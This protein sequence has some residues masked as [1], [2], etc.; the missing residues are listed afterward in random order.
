M[1]H[2]INAKFIKCCALCKYWDD[3]ARTA[4]KPTYAKNIWD[5]DISQNR[6]CMKKRMKMKAVG[7]CTQY[8]AKIEVL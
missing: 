6:L 5:I 7:N 4:A 8:E 2:K 1:A 3:P